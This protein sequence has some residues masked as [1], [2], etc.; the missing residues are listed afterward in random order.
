MIESVPTNSA[1]LDL[2]FSPSS[3]FDEANISD[4]RFAVATSAG[5]IEIH[6]ITFSTQ[7]DLT[8]TLWCIHT[9]QAYDPSLL[10]LSLAFNPLASPSE[11][12]AVTLSGGSVA[13][14]DCGEAVQSHSLEAWTVAWSSLVDVD[15]RQSLYS[16]GDDSMLRILSYSS[17]ATNQNEPRLLVSQSIAGIHGAD[18]SGYYKDN[19]GGKSI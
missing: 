11:V 14:F 16:G 3:K 9:I 19:N 7:P 6:C 4:A 1:V 2:H 17:G 10:V 8:A 12:L 5:T 13:V 15:H 18:M